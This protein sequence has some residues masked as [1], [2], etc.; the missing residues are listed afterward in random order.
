MDLASISELKDLISLLKNSVNAS[1]KRT[2]ANYCPKNFPKKLGS[3]YQKC[4]EENK[5]LIDSLFLIGQAKFIF[6]NLDGVKDFDTQLE[7]LLK[8]LEEVEKFYP[9][10]VIGYH[11]LALELIEKKETSKEEYSYSPP[12]SFDI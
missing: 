11:L 1:Q 2:L 4:S 7:E 8:I 9:G 12:L 5:W 3:F 10:G 6:Q